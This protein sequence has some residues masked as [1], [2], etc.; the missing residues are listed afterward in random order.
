MGNKE[1][2]Q[3][4]AIALVQALMLS[5]GASVLIA[6]LTAWLVCQNVI[7][8]YATDYGAMLALLI[9]SIVSSAVLAG[10]GKGMRL[11]LCIGGAVLYLLVMAL[12]SVLLFDGVTDGFL[13]TA[14]VVFAGSMVANL[15]RFRRNK[16]PKFRVPRSRI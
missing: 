6:M 10:K 11:W 1:D 2:I 9:G 3:Q 8:E 13:A 16:Q 14:A 15:L 5:I 4:W 12:G 7:A